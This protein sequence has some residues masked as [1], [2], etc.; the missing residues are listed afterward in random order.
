MRG[1]SETEVGM[2]RAIALTTL[3]VTLTLAVPV[4]SDARG[5]Q[6]T[7]PMDLTLRSREE[8]PGAEGVYRAVEREETWQPEATAVIVCDMWDLHHCLN[9]T[10]R[11]AELAPRMDQVLRDARRRG[12][13]I[14]HAPSSCMAAYEGH[15]SRDRAIQTPRSGTLPP[16]IGQ[17]CDQIPAEEGGQYPI[18][19]SDGGEDDD[20]A[21][22]AAWA[23]KLSSMG[24]NPRSPWKSQTDRL[25]IDPERDYISDDGEE[26]WSILEDRSIDNVILLGVHTNMCVLGRPFGLRQMAKNGKNVVLM[27]DMTDTMYNPARPPF[28]SHYTGTDRI[29]EHIEKFVCP[30]ITSDQLIG[31][32][33]FRFQ[34]D[35]RPHVVFL[36]AED[37][38]ETEQT[39]PPFAEESLGRDYRVSFVFGSD[40]D[41]HALDSL[42]VLE[43]ADLMFVSMR[44]RPLRADQ[45]ARIRDHVARGKPVIG[46]RTAS[47]GFS[48]RG[49]SELPEGVASWPEFDAQV[50]GGSYTN[51]H[52]NGIESAI[53]VADSCKGH[54]IL[55][56]VDAS[57]LIGKGSLYKVRPLA[58]STTPLLIGAIPDQEPEPVAWTHLGPTGSRVFYTSLGHRGDFEQPSFRRLLRNAI[59][60]SLEPLSFPQSP[61]QPAQSSEVAAER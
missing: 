3:L 56:G 40:D 29:V 1:I 47:H 58:S 13:T 25:H 49:N 53:S 44:R 46:I 57:T 61:P 50:L 38:Y 32:K 16:D 28:V 9:A 41:Q 45:L 26:I 17:W 39:L 15:P 10:R 43:D 59:D 8:L 35:R 60:W 30:T 42:G 20:P 33:P 11:G 18:D 54:P 23:E 19:Q 12:A 27:R 5:D 34:D 48:L 14:I 6:E 31:G 24:R 52:P 21:E 37:E 2:A 51:H 4:H 22:H 36:I 7:G 55:E